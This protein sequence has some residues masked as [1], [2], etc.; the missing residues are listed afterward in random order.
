MSETKDIKEFLDKKQEN[1]SEKTLDEIYKS[2]SDASNFVLNFLLTLLMG[3][4]AINEI[5][6]AFIF[7]QKLAFSKMA[8]WMKF[9]EKYW[10]DL[11]LKS[12]YLTNIAGEIFVK[13]FVEFLAKQQGLN[14]ETHEYKA[15]LD[16]CF[17]FVKSENIIKKDPNKLFLA[18]KDLEI[19]KTVSVK[20]VKKEV[21]KE[22]PKNKVVDISNFVEITEALPAFNVEDWDE[23]NILNI[24]PNITLNEVVARVNSFPGITNYALDQILQETGDFRQLY[25]N[26][27][28]WIC[29][30]FR[31]NE[32]RSVREQVFKICKSSKVKYQF[33]LIG[34]WMLTKEKLTADRG[35]SLK[36][37]ETFARNHKEAQRFLNDCLAYVE[38]FDTRLEKNNFLRKI[39]PQKL[40]KQN[41]ENSVFNWKGKKVA[42]VGQNSLFS[43]NIWKTSTGKQ[44]AF[45]CF[46]WICLNYEY[47]EEH[48]Y[49]IDQIL[50]FGINIKRINYSS[51]NT[52]EHWHEA[53]NSS[54]LW[55]D[56]SME[57]MIWELDVE[58]VYFAAACQI[59][60]SKHYEVNERKKILEKIFNSLRPVEAS[61]KRS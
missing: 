5:I 10:K 30:H 4:P 25:N 37:F 38:K 2:D 36:E 27:M 19:K 52:K 46:K 50:G 13:R 18:S 32:R 45:D 9:Q 28:A 53:R 44:L 42:L 60:I 29:N 34:E 7:P 8:D 41:C 1:Y 21:E 22:I 61:Q 58:A 12:I 23:D 17:P 14:L 35:F 48:Q 11:S 26:V 33:K 16:L 6:E 20:I 47:P 40:G 55:I 43:N 51:L 15:Y 54:A 57:R 24:D 49:L 39:F 56:S 31:E 3:N 59:W